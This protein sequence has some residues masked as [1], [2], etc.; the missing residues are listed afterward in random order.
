MTSLEMRAPCKE[1][2]H[3]MGYRT[4]TNGQAVI[5][6]SACGT[7]AYNA[8]KLELGEEPSQ[9][10]TRPNI[11][12]K[13]KVRILERDH[14][15]CVLCN[16]SGVPLH[17]GHLISVDDGRRV[18]MPDSDLWDDRNLAA[19]CDECNLGLG[20]SSVSVILQARLFYIWKKADESA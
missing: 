7:Y 14:H 17:V 10:R 4:Q 9:V 12:P 19:M 2:S 8:P 1:C 5:R 15:T 16:N 6:C 18:G 11:K 13:Q 20:R 3:T